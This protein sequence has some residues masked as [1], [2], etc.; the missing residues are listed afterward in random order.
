MVISKLV[1]KSSAD[2]TGISSYGRW[3]IITCVPPCCSNSLTESTLRPLNGSRCRWLSRMG[4]VMGATGSLQKAGS[5][6]FLC[7]LVHSGSNV[8]GFPCS[9]ADQFAASEKKDNDF[10]FVE[11]VDQSRELLRLVLDLL[12]SKADRDRIEIDSCSTVA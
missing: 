8:L 2:L 10:R 7:D 6:E 1:R 12:Q 5:L 4:G 9:C 3:E 11:P